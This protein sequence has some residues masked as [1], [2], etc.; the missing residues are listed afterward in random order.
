MST[1]INHIFNQSSCLT[2]REVEQY[3][4]G[5]LNAEEL[6]RVELHIAD[7]PMCSDE[8]DGY[9]LLKDKKTLPNIIDSLNEKIDKSATASKTIPLHSS[10]KKSLTKRFISIAA[11]LILLLGAG[12]IINFYMNSEKNNLAEAPLTEKIKPG[13]KEITDENIN[14]E[15]KYSEKSITEKNIIENDTKNIDNLRKDNKVENDKIADVET[16]D[17]TVKTALSEKEND[18]VKEEK[19]EDKKEISNDIIFSAGSADDRTTKEKNDISVGSSINEPKLSENK[20]SSNDISFM[21]TRGA[22][23]KNKNTVSKKEIEKYKSLRES[24]LLSYG[25]N[26]YDEVLKD[27]NSYLKYKPNDYEIL[28]KTGFSNYKLKHYNKAIS[29]FNKVISEGIN[30]YAEDARWY[31]ANSLIKLGKKEDAKTILNSII[32]KNGKYQN[33]ALDLLN[34]LN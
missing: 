21:I 6:R 9:T 29:N 2:S 18:K 25:M 33:Q 32:V 24:A 17:N 12:Y 23:F 1:E 16:E 20:K 3:V 14:N 27:F 7:C 31:K 10:S 5:T 30:R 34:N 8:I 19:A 15:K 13:E 11:S 26:I 28:Y 22:K 4:S